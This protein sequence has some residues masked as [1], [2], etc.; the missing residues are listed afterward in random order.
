MHIVAR[1]KLESKSMKTIKLLVCLG[2]AV[3]FAGLSPVGAQ[4]LQK[5]QKPTKPLCTTIPQQVLVYS[6]GH[7][8]AGQLIPL[9]SDIFGYNYQAHKFKGY[10]INAYLGEDGFPP[11]TGDAAAYLT[12]NPEA[13]TWSYWP[14]R[15]TFL[16]MAWNDA[17]LSN[18][19]CDG[20]GILDRHYGSPSYRGSGAL[21]TNLLWGK[22]EDGN[23]WTTFAMF[24]AA[25]LNATEVDG[26]WYDARGRKIGEEIWGNFA[27]V[28]EVNHTFNKAHRGNRHCGPAGTGHGRR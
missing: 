7:Y 9:G 15:D 20:D 19:D 17:W 26:I 12:A 16:E 18:K 25:P 1:A 3:L 10:L 13:A 22:N 28:L 8:L 4:T 11:Y 24:V 14:D 2:V 23:W 21:L 27:I 5:S 6:E